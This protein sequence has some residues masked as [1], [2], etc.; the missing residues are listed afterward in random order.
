[1]GTY[2][3]LTINIETFVD[4]HP[5]GSMKNNKWASEKHELVT[6]T[7]LK[8]DLCG[9]LDLENHMDSLSQ[10]HLGSCL[11]CCSTIGKTGAKGLFD[12]AWQKG[13]KPDRT[14][15][16]ASIVYRKI[17]NVH[18]LF[19]LDWKHVLDVNSERICHKPIRTLWNWCLVYCSILNAISIYIIQNMSVS[20]VFAYV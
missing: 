4:P 10:C 7:Y 14:E 8:R 15:L 2:Y 17:T 19:L 5:P 18:I 3:T 20:T 9:R 1:M 11:R 13:Q 6:R 16:G 12:L